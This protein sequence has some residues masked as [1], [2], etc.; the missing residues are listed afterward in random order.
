MFDE[1][2]PVQGYEAGVSRNERGF[3]KRVAM[4]RMTKFLVSSKC[5]SHTWVRF[6]W[7]SRGGSNP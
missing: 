2:S 1:R 3:L 4:E 5:V 7:W 6:W